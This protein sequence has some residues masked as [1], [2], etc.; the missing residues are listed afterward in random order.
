VWSAGGTVDGSPSRRR[1]S[2]P[3]AGTG[4][5]AST[6]GALLATSGAEARIDNIS[7]NDVNVSNDRGELHKVTVDPTFELTWSGFDDAVA[8]VMMV[9][10]ANWRSQGFSPVFRMTPWLDP[11]GSS[12]AY[13]DSSG[14]GTSGHFKIKKAL[15]EALAQD[16]RYSTTP[17]P[18]PVEVANRIGRPDYQAGTY[19]GG[20]TASTYVDGSSLG[21]ASYDHGSIQAALV[22][23]FPTIDA[24]YYGAA[25]DASEV[26]V[27]TD[28]GS[29]DAALEVRYTFAFIRPNDGYMSA[30]YSGYGGPSNARSVSGGAIE[31]SDIYSG[32]THSAIC[33]T[34]TT[35]KNYAGARSIGEPSV[36][37]ATTDFKT[38]VRNVTNASSD[39]VT[40][41]TGGS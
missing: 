3:S 8:K 27:A 29:D 32:S 11:G 12:T 21:S 14:P 13:V 31:A 25:G 5:P 16:P 33:M 20:V 38:S 6:G 17:T 7:S 4:P 1:Q 26:D 36:L 28:G 35:S 18:R 37:S 41:G 39:N 19:P 22:N 34:T 24:G 15:S 10:E 40:S 23:N 2:L 30:M 9:V